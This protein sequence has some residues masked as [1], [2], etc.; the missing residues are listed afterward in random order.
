MQVV[1]S[2]QHWQ[3]WFHRRPILLIGFALLCRVPYRAVLCAVL[4]RAVLCR[5]AQHDRSRFAA[6]FK[7]QF[8]AQEE[9]SLR[10]RTAPTTNAQRPQLC[11]CMVRG[12]TVRGGGGG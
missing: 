9:E 12:V 6:S 4:C 7:K 10:Q 5:A 1:H 11:D 8:A 3:L 2:E